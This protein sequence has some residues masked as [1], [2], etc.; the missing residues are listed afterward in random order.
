MSSWSEIRARSFDP[1][2]ASINSL[3]LRVNQNNAISEEITDSETIFPLRVLTGK[4]E[5]SDK[6]LTTG[7][8]RSKNQNFYLPFETDGKVVKL[9]SRFDCGGVDVPDYSHY[10][11]KIEIRH[12]ATAPQPELIM[13]AED[14]GVAG[15][16][17]SSHLEY[18]KKHYFRIIDPEFSLEDDESY[19]FFL[20]ISPTIIDNQMRTDG[21]KRATLLSYIENDQVSHAV[22]IEID[23]E[24]YFY[25]WVRDNFIDYFVKSDEPLVEFPDV[26]DYYAQDYAEEDYYA[27]ADDDTFAIPVPFTYIFCSFNKELK[28]ARMRKVVD[29]Q[30][31][32]TYSSGDI[33]IP[34]WN[35]LSLWLPLTDGG[36]TEDVVD[37]S[38]LDNHG[39]FA[40][41]TIKPEWVTR[42]GKRVLEF[43]DDGCYLTVPNA[44]SLNTFT[45][46]TVSFWANLYD[47]FY[48]IAHSK[49]LFRKGLTGN[50]RFLIYNATG[51]NRAINID[52]V[53]NSGTSRFLGS[54][55]TLMPDA[56]GIVHIVVTYDGSNYKFYINGQQTAN[57]HSHSGDEFTNSG[58]VYIGSGTSNFGGHQNIMHFMLWKNQALDSTEVS[59]LYNAF[60][61]LVSE[62]TNLLPEGEPPFPEYQPEPPEPPAPGTPTTLPFT[63]TPYNQTTGSSF[64]R[65]NQVTVSG[66]D[67]IYNVAGGEP[68]EDPV[69]NIY[70]VAPGIYTEGVEGEDE[71]ET[72]YN[73]TN[74]SD[75]S[76]GE[77]K[78]NEKAYGQR[79][80]NNSSVLRGKKITEIS[81][82]L[83]D[84][85]AGAASGGTLNL[86]VIKSNGDVITFG[87][88]IDASSLTGSYQTFTRSNSSNDYVMANGDAVGVIWT[89]G[90]RS[91]SINI[92]RGGS[93]N[94]YENS[95]YSSQCIH[96]GSSWGSH[97]TTYSM[98]AT[99][100]S[101]TATPGTPT[102]DPYLRISGGASGS[103]FDR[104]YEVG[105]LFGT[106]SPMIGQTPTKI[107]IRVHRHASANS[108]NIYLRHVDSNNNVKN[109]LKS[110]TISSLPTTVP[111]TFNWTWEDLTYNTPIANNDRILVVVDTT[112]TNPVYVLGNEGVTGTPASYDSPNTRSCVV[113][114]RTAYPGV[115]G[116][117]ARPEAWVSNTARDISGKIYKGGNN[118]TGYISLNATRK[119]TGIK[120]AA[121]ASSLKGKKITKVTATMKT[122]GT[123]TSGA[124]YCRIRNSAG[125]ERVTL[126]QVDITS[127]E[128][129]DT[130]V[131][132]LNT[133]H[134]ITLN[135]DDTISLEYE[136]GDAENYIDVRVN[137]NAFETTNTIL[138]ESLQASINTATVVSDRDLAAVLYTGGEIDTNARPRVGISV[139]NSNSSLFDRAITKIKLWLKREGSGFEEG[140]KI[141]VKV[142]RGT[143]KVPVT[144]LGEQ[145]ILDIPTSDTEYTFENTANAYSMKAGDMI[146]VENLH[147]DATNYV[148]V[149]I[150]NTQA[151]DDTST[152]L[153]Q[154]TGTAYN[155]DT[156]KDVN[157]ICYTGGYTVYPDPLIP[158]PPQPYYY[159]HDLFFG[160]QTTPSGQ[161]E[162]DT[163][164]LDP[165]PDSMFSFIAGELRLYQGRTIEEE[166]VLN[167]WT[168]KHTISAIAFGSPAVVAHFVIPT[169]SAP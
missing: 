121:D 163:A 78:N 80:S 46:W 151:I 112:N 12:A 144:T 117:G 22:K 118:F 56:P 30:T 93:G 91:G 167:L 20:K 138:F 120:V 146:V 127:I 159:S 51:D 39:S 69:T 71:I 48:S 41:S 94:H 123:L 145:E 15:N 107:E 75:N 32:L 119:R 34:Q 23:D 40:E 67:E 77:L 136:L 137:K 108:G 11:N 153:I 164:T 129:T 90:G 66:L 2:S 128:S 81:V 65:V 140:D 9:W 3:I 97:N 126:N 18:Q 143:D 169:T 83:K 5:I 29:G 82:R 92:L 115:F 96:N 45:S 148:L 165:D 61:P 42:D 149:K 37:L 7:Y 35:N 154:W 156:A 133:T 50:G 130:S 60:L 102:I 105:E 113:Y 122:V 21:A 150:S 76:H 100:K 53:N 158:V 10:K 25:F 131:D 132:F 19:A 33:E 104:Y 57:V 99:I 70:D 109:T 8:A 24:G 86:G 74:G 124:V 52:V 101:G 43:E 161:G 147:G 27:S 49:I 47:D 59:A 125:S 139:N 157:A 62:N 13:A 84:G 63:E 88:N 64:T 79:I 89:G 68:V 38:G 44:T 160:A 14:D 85:P 54:G 6:R 26:P 16:K 116:F 141:S 103:D 110:A 17:I 73:L 135:K 111:T 134:S 142:I 106:G 155:L 36:N 31:V 4:M 55:S 28:R 1:L 162:I 152:C 87:S 95:S 114:R 58:D 166:E 168:N 72:I 98:A